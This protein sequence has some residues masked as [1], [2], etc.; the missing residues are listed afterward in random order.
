VTTVRAGSMMD[1]D[2]TWDVDPA[3]LG[4]LAQAAMGVGLNLA[5]RPVSQ[6]ASVTNTFRAL[7]DLPPDLHTAVVHLHA[8]KAD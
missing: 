3:I 1:A 6:F 4:R 7:I 2:K 5:E 8:R